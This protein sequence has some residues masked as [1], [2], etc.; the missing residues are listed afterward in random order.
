MTEELNEDVSIQLS[1]ERLLTA[2]LKNI[3]EIELAIEDVVADYTQFEIEVTQE[4]DDF[5]IFNLVERS[6]NDGS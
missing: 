1:A 4:R 3:G 6:S 2:V 5:I